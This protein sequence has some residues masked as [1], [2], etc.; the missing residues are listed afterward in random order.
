MRS[1]RSLVLAAALI[2]IATVAG[3]DGPFQF[4]SVVPC[5]IIDTRSNGG[6]LVS[7]ETRSFAIGGTCGIPAGA[8]MAALNF[9]VIGPTASGHITVFPYNTTLPGTST[10]TYSGGESALTNGSVVSLT[11][12]MTWGISVNNAGSQL[13]L[14]ID[15][16]GYL[17]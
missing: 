13:N 1:H 15:A 7:G 6:P 11:P 8:K 16:T 14:I 17:Q 12:N 2:S 3:A 9:T 4:Y 10:L 5:R